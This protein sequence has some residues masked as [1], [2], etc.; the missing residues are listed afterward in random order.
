MNNFDDILLELRYRVPEGIVD[1]TKEHQ[2]NEL[3]NILKENG[4]SDAN[5]L[6]QKARVYFSYL[7]EI[8]EA[9]PVKKGKSNPI[10]DIDKVLQ[11][12]VKNTETGNDIT[13]QSALQYKNSKSAGQKAAYG[14]AVNLLKK[15]GVSDKEIGGLSK[16]SEKPAAPKAT[17]NVT[18]A[19]KA[20]AAKQSKGRKPEEIK[21]EIDRISVEA[22]QS[23]DDFYK[24][25]YHKSEGEDDAGAAPG[26]AGSMLNENGSCDVCEWALEND[27]N[28]LVEAVK[29]LYGNLK[30]G[31]LLDAT[32]KTGI[33]GQEDRVP[34]VSAGQ[35][36]AF[37]EAGKGA[38][39]NLSDGQLSRL[40]MAANGGLIK[41]RKIKEGI[42]SNKWKEED[43][44]VNGFFG[45]AGGKAQQIDMVRQSNRIFAPDGREIPKEE[46]LKLVAAGGGGANPSDTSQFVY[47][48]KTGDLMI[49]FTSDKDSFDAIVAQSS[50]QKEGSIKKEQIDELVKNNKLNKA[51]GEKLR[52]LIDK[53]TQKLNAIESELKTVVVEPAKKMMSK[54]P[55]ELYKLALEF[56]TSSNGKSRLAVIEKK[57]GKGGD[58]I[59]NLLKAAATN[60]ESLS[61]GDRRVVDDLKKHYGLDYLVAEKI[62]NIRK[63]SI[64]VERK[65]LDEMNKIKVP[66]SEGKVGL[67]DY[68]DATNFIDKFHMAGAM[69]DKHGVFAYGGLFEVVCGV[70]V[71]NND[72]IASCMNTNKMDDFIKKFGST[73]EEFQLS[74]ENQITG[75]VRIAY[76]LNDRGEKIRIGEKRQRSKTGAT[77]RFNTVYKWDKDTIACFKRK[78]G[79]A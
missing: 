22:G 74:K 71:I 5:E 67:G 36:K 2:I 50:F 4:Y 23:R 68:M 28:N 35:L 77:G 21:K 45:D 55:K 9:N 56:N 62:D 34:S 6:A 20:D 3:V 70:G 49:K 41:G 59:K 61:S 65:M 66:I 29:H 18:G 78:N 52:Q 1:L 10:S 31:A 46:A 37:R 72:I 8:E 38:F 51:G 75:S 73:K 15:S 17:I 7:K 43:C 57:Y 11:K 25:G 64:A 53:Q 79:V 47:N 48:Q 60:P 26:N 69:G 54:Q 39:K 13:V 40:M 30:G 63:R 27:S 42:K 12:K 58:G 16:K 14:Q 19:E 33:A 32:D 44:I 24:K 76:F